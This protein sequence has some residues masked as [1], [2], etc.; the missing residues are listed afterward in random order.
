MGISI[1]TPRAAQWWQRNWFI[2][3]PLVVYLITYA[4]VFPGIDSF[5]S[6]DQRGQFAQG[7]FNKQHSV[8]STFFLG[9]IGHNEL[10]LCNL[11]QAIIFS[12]CI[13]TALAVLASRI[14]RRALL[15]ATLVWSFYPLFPAYAVSSTK[16]V[17]NAGLTLLLCVQIFEI[18]NSG[19]T[20][21]HRPW[22]VVGLGLTM[23]LTNEWRKNNF[24][25][26]IAI[27]VFLLIRYRRKWKQLVAAL[28][29]FATL[30]TAWGAY[31]DRV[32]HATPSSTTE[33]LGVP[34]MQVSYIYYQDVNGNPQQLP[35]RADAYFQAIR[36]AQDWASNYQAERTV[37]MTNK[38]PQL[39]PDDLGAFLGNWSSLCLA[40]PGTCVKAYL[41]FEG[42]LINPFQQT[43]DQYSIA[44]AV[45]GTDKAQASHS[46]AA[47][48]A[49]IVF[50]LA[51]LDWSIIALA[52][53]ACQRGRRELLPL[54]LIPLGIAFSLML[55][56]LAVQIRLMLGAIILIPFLAALILGRPRNSPPSDFVANR[57][58]TQ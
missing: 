55:A 20:I 3:T 51:L 9:V 53:L 10:W 31:C 39:T 23:F 42:S 46:I 33:M 28:L 58:S 15:I 49:R 24:V 4:V 29:I 22:F 40:N 32:L 7:T 25:F 48:P 56:A 37:V 44:A 54:F 16:D 27:A 14:S 36:P 21:L 5:D 11:M 8:L 35:E 57:T 13:I 52:V 18:I 2:L 26:L 19:G 1:N 30:T 38:V 41:L 43:D 50:N 6:A 17:L 34:L 45:L 47:V 12:L